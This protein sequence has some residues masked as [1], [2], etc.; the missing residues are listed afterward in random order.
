MLQT[1]VLEI[2]VF[3]PK[4]GEAWAPPIHL[5][6]SGMHSFRHSS[7]FRAVCHSSAIVAKKLPTSLIPI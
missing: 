1:S 4:V 2:G 6:S 5:P 7:L 3:E